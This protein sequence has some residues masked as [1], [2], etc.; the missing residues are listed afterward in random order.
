MLTDGTR[1]AKV[2]AETS[3]RR[4]FEQLFGQ[5][6]ACPVAD[7]APSVEKDNKHSSFGKPKCAV[8]YARCLGCAPRQLSISLGRQAVSEHRH[9]LAPRLPPRAAVTAAMV[10]LASPS[11]FISTATLPAAFRIPQAR[12]DCRL[13]FLPFPLGKSIGQAKVEATAGNEPAQL[14]GRPG[15]KAPLRLT[16][17]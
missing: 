17:G 10:G 11:A 6:T 2:G 5:T 7:S 13:A 9:C 1:A 3:V 4:R 12:L 15:C 8:R 14:G 16:A